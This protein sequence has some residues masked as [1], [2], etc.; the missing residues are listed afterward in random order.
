MWK[1]AVGFGSII[2][3]IAM[4]GLAI[5]Y[6]KQYKDEKNAKIRYDS[7]SN[8][9][10]AE[11]DKCISFL[12]VL[13]NQ[14]GPLQEVIVP[15]EKMKRI[16]ER[17]PEKANSTYRMTEYIIPLTKKLAD[18]YNFYYEHSRDGNNS[19]KTMESCEE[20]LKGLSEILH[21]KADSML[22]DQFYDVHAEVSA[23]LQLHSIS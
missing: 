3:F 11:I 1:L 2:F 12:S 15:L 20:G 16:I 4:I 21:K 17:Y 5:Y 9:I 14:A 19:A 22:E 18:D 23:L 6:I 13:P 10:L 8:D 7:N